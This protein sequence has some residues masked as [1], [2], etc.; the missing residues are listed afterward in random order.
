[1]N[2]FFVK[3]NQIKSKE[4]SVMTEFRTPTDISE[5]EKI[6]GGILDSQQLL[7]LALGI[8]ITVGVGLLCSGFMGGVGFIIGAVIGLPIGICFAFVKPRKMPLMKFI[9]LKMARRKHI[10]HLPNHDPE[11]DEIEFNYYAIERL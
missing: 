4:E 11:I 5:K 3:I 8:G 9:R 7:W 10:K 1:M 6:V 2:L